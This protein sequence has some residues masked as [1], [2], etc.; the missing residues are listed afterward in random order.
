MHVQLGAGGVSESQLSAIATE[1]LRR[2]PVYAAL[3][4]AAL[5]ATSVEVRTA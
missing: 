1:G 4:A 5:V 2:S 3:A